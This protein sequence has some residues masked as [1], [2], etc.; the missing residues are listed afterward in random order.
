MCGGGKGEFLI[1]KTMEK[2]EGGGPILR[3]RNGSPA[4]FTKKGFPKQGTNIS[5]TNNNRQ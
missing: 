4:G 1:S 3:H 5:P 2:P